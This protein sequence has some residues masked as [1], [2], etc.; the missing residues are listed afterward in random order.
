MNLQQKMLAEMKAEMDART[1]AI[2]AAADLCHEAD[3]MAEALSE[4]G[5]DV[6]ALGSSFPGFLPQRSVNIWVVKTGADLKSCD[7]LEAVFV[8]DLVVRGT[9]HEPDPN[10][11]DVVWLAFAELEVELRVALRGDEAAALVRAFS[12]RATDPSLIGRSDLAAWRS[13]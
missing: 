7:V 9:T 13:A 5:L 2:V 1:A 8:A 11:L 4:A 3:T 6:V 12:P 10:D